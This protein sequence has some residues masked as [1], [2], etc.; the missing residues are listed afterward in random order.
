MPEKVSVLPPFFT[1]ETA[2]EPLLTT[3]L[4][5]VAVLLA[6]T[7]SEAAVFNVAPAVRLPPV[8]TLAAPLSSRPPVAIVR[9]SA[10]ELS[11]A[12]DTALT[13]NELIVRVVTPETLAPI[14][15]LSRDPPAVRRLAEYAG[16]PVLPSA[17]TPP[18]VPL[19]VT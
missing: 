17:P 15:M 8:I 4:A 10:L 7:N 13:R 14:L 12:V 3:L 1:K 9:I 19:E 2:P 5:M 16:N 11:V 6:N 18:C